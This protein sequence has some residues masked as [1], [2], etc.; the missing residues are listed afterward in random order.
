MPCDVPTKGEE[1][2]R[3]KKDDKEPSVGD[4]ESSGRLHHKTRAGYGCKPRQSTFGRCGT[5]D[6]ARTHTA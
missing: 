2:V 4:C 5:D 6:V 1:G 3:A